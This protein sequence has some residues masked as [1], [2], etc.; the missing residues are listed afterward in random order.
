MTVSIVVIMFELTGAMH[1]VLPTI[2]IVV[3]AKFVGDLVGGKDGHS[4]L[5][6]QMEEY[7][8]LETKEDYHFSAR[9]ADIMTSAEK[10][11]VLSNG[12]TIEGVEQLLAS[13]TMNTYPIV[14]DRLSMSLEGCITR[15]DL[16]Y[17]IGTFPLDSGFN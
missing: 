6:I 11:V 13:T 2:M 7:P 15:N 8:F 5:F 14:D 1:F 16:R 3:L 9:A 4:N 17:A 10:L 12:I